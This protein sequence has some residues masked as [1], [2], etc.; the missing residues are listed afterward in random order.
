MYI[1]GKGVGSALALASVAVLAG[2]FA[3]IGYPRSPTVA[4]DY[5]EC[6]NEARAN[7]ASAADYSR[8]IT[9][10]S[11]HFAGRRK[12]RGGYTNFDFMQNRSFDIAGPNPT[13]DE[14]KQIDLSY[15]EFLRAQRQEVL[16][17]DLAKAKDDQEQAA[18]ERSQEDVHQP[19]SLVPKVPLPVKRPP[20]QASKVCE[21]GSL[22]C[23]LAK[24]SA[25][26]RN[27]FASTNADR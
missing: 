15:M 27:A 3:W 9:D 25:A 1:L 2:A 14:R 16:S 5:E 26:V 11:S 6:T 10:C 22:A 7:I 17:S 8:Q 18:F 20:I 23:S 24:L 21:D 4:R 12:V 19:L 13:A